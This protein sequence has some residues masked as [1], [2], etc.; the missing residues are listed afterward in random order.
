MHADEWQCFICQE[1]SVEYSGLTLHEPWPMM[2]A[3][4]MATQMEY[5]DGV[6]V[7]QH[8]PGN[9]HACSVTMFLLCRGK[10]VWA[11]RYITR[12]LI[13][14]SAGRCNIVCPF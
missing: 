13:P 9:V 14:I 8:H 12:L 2:E 5:A 6:C 3:C 1:W 4:Q 10:D 11:A 7:L